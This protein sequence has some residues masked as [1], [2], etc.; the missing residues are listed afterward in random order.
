M[1]ERRSQSQ[2]S[3]DSFIINTGGSS[4]SPSRSGGRSFGGGS[5]RGGSS[6]SSG[7]D[8]RGGDRGGYS[9]DRGSRSFSSDR[10]GRSFGGGGSRFGGGGRGGN[11]GG[12]RRS[13]INEGLYVRKASDVVIKEYESKHTFNDFEIHPALKERIERRGYTIPTAIQD[14][15]IPLVLQGRDIIGLANTGTGKTAAFLI[16]VIDKI[17]KS[18]KNDSGLPER[19]LIKPGA[20]GSTQVIA[21]SKFAKTEGERPA[22]PARD[23]AKRWERPDRGDRPEF[24]Y[25]IENE[26]KCLVVVPTRELATQIEDELMAFAPDLRIFSAVCVGG[27]NMQ[28]QI[29]R[30][31]KIC[32][33]VIGTPGRL[34][35][36]IDRGHLDLGKFDSIV[37]DEVDRM[38]DMGF[39]DDVSN[40][41]GML[42]G[43]KHSMF[44]SATMEPRLKPICEK[45]LKDPTTISVI[46]GKTSDYVDQDIVRV[47]RGENKFEKLVEILN[48]DTVDKVLIFCQRKMDVDDLE[49][50]L[51]RAGF[52]VESLHGD[53]K[54]RTRDIAI[55]RFKQGEVKILIATDVAARGLD[56]PKVTHVINYD[57]PDN[58]DDYTHR[59]GRAGR[60]GNKGWALTFVN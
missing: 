8:D 52:S 3:F 43:H 21:N 58:Y 51:D 45:L 40:L 18:R 7:R 17:L 37:L 48:G 55:K 19:E 44:F 5:S 46:Q 25:F 56:I 22:R 36:L 53:K 15:A 24:K 39:I 9:S 59:I 50:Q 27:T 28:R 31:N 32:Q 38:M 41:V 20:A 33:I 10:S 49:H 13:D 54:Q 11:R 2:Q 6:Y 23:G 30:L 26:P 60:A 16:P 35:D 47:A 14:Q 29:S 1:G 34:L 12:G 57:K 42:P 4:S